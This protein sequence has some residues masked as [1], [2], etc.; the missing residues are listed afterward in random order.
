MYTEFLLKLPDTAAYEKLPQEKIDGMKR[1][2]YSAFDTALPDDYTELLKHT[3]GLSYDGHSICGVYDEE[4][5]IDHP[6]K[7]SMDILR[8]NSSF[9][10]M[11]DITDYILLGKSS[12]DLIVYNIGEKKYQILSSGVMECFGTFD[13]F[14]ELLYAFFDAEK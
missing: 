8:F 7:K 5:L 1:E 14:L 10:D 6:R 13:T 12:I 11:T 4:F 9:R 3:N 2:F